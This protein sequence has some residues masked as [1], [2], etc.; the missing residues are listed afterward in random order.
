M[1]GGIGF[2]DWLD[3]GYRFP[4]KRLCSNTW[5]PQHLS[6]SGS[7]QG[8]VS[9]PSPPSPDNQQN[10]ETDAKP[11]PVEALPAKDAK[12]DENGV[13]DVVPNWRTPE[14]VRSLAC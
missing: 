1:A 3:G 11:N 6:K 8:C 2:S 4:R 10:G 14:P 9:R 7:E 13:T 12:R 5:K